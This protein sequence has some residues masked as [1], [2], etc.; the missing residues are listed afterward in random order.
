MGHPNA[1]PLTKEQVA[2]IYLG[3][4]QAAQP[5]D[6]PEASPIRASFYEKAT[7]KDAAQIK[8]TWARLAFSGKAQPPKEAADAAAVKKEV[9]NN[10]KAVG[11]IDKSAADASVKVLLTLP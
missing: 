1:A 5:I 6:L 3:K 10:P 2:E 8:A 11:Y 4:S 7:G 9:A